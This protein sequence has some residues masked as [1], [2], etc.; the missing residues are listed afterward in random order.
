V[1]AL[2]LLFPS[3]L[4]GQ[5]TTHTDT[6]AEARLQQHYDAAR[7]FQLSG[8]Q[9]HAAAEY[10][11]FLSGA[12]D[13]CA[14]ADAQARQFSKAADLFEGALGIAP[15]DA[16]IRLDYAF[17]RLR[18][19]KLQEARSLAEK[20]LATQP[21]AK[22]RAL[23][24]QIL[25]AK[26]EYQTAREQL[27]AVVTSSPSFDV[28][29]LL[30][31]TY[32]KLNDLARARLLF[33]DM[34]SG[35]GDTARLHIYFG[36]AYGEGETESLDKAIDEF[37]KAIALDAKIAQ[38][39]YFLA[40]AYLNRDGESGFAEAAPELEAELQLSPDDARS[41]YL[42]GYIA[43]KQHDI[44]R[45]E[46]V[47][48]QAAKLEPA[49]PDPLIYLGQIYADSDR[50]SQA[51]ATMRKAITLTADVSRNNYQINR[52]HYALG[53]ILLH[54]GRREDGEKELNVS[55]DLR[56]RVAHPELA[57]N[58][59]AP[60]FAS[61]SLDEQAADT[62][63][64]PVS[65]EEQKKA[66]S[67]VD[68]LRPAIADAYNNLGVIFAAQRRFADALDQFRMAGEWNPSLATL[69]RNWG[70]AG[71]YAEKYEDA[72]APLS[73]HLK[74]R[75]DDI[76][77]RAALGLSFFMAQKFEKAL[78]TLR[79]AQAT[80]DDDP[81]LS[82]A[83]AVSLVKTGDYTEGVR[84]LQLLDKAN[85]N[86]ADIHMLLGEAFAD[87]QEYAT[88]LDEYRKSLAIDPGQPQTHFLTGLALLRKGGPVEAVQEFRTALRLSPNDASK[89]YHLAYALIE[90]QQKDEALALLQEVIRQNPKYAD[91]FYQVGK[92]QLERGDAKSAISNLETGTK[93][94]PDSDYIHYQLAMAYRRDARAQ[95]AEREIKLYQVLKNQHRGRDVSQAN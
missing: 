53:R 6:S 40:L 10:K 84:R 30:G 74:A 58:Q 66:A 42:L 61:A 24:G 80:V 93:L 48:L 81:G 92:L 60:E 63:P 2:L 33:D 95:D 68:R 77:A 34:I 72:V 78:E 38:A 82:Y 45:A 73:R 71:F 83:Y 15:E 88:A 64:P 49:N 70:M 39:H 91:A 55:K 57:R 19:G 9:E 46:S 25:F 3:L 87:Q 59:K 22:A 43:M 31:R 65:A 52:A 7:T 50:E 44:R 32:I 94:S 27:E 17:L 85:P 76:R 20:V 35:L 90:T 37:K 79:P 67:Q 89:K 1:L 8:D 11:A 23:L 29:Y 26:G 86:S 36:R 47:L 69:D 51:E 18:Q 16:D 21:T 56:D 28:G 54:T 13:T 41:Y 4:A 14:N 12:L 62:V 5:L 75:P